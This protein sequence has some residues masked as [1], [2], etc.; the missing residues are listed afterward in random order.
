MFEYVLFSVHVDALQ[1][2]I[3]LDY[4]YITYMVVLVDYIILT[5]TYMY[6]YIK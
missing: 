5:C 3:L 4:M 6:M 2:L 1:Y